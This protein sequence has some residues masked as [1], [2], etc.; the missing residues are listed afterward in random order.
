MEFVAMRILIATTR[1]GIV[2]GVETYLR[3]VLPA[4][5][6]RGH[7]VALLYELP[8]EVGAAAIDRD[9]PGL[10]AWRLDARD[11]SGSLSPATAWAPDI[12]YSQGL[13]GPATEEALLERFPVTLFAHNYHGTC[14]SGTK[15]HRLPT[16]RPCARTLG[17][18]CLMLYYPRR[19]GGLSPRT[20]LRD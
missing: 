20:L 1:R 15:R 3:A 5:V 14:V 2:G 18:C 13:Q 12:V 9:L 16:S 11:L 17:P 7:D 19:C 10:F 6:E 8:V 4:L